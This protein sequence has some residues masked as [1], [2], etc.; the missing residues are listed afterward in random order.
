MAALS[1]A[2]QGA[3]APNWMG[4]PVVVGWR[5]REAGPS[6]RKLHECKR[7]RGTKALRSG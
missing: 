7:S 5:S 2:V 3:F 1:K 4:T 6:F